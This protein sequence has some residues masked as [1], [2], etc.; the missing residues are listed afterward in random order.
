MLKPHIVFDIE[1]VL[2]EDAVAR[3]H[4]LA[5]GDVN[6]VKAVIGDT[7]PKP[8]FHKIVAI[9][10]TTLTYDNYS[11]QWSVLEMASLHTG[12]QTEKDLVGK[13]V[14]YV[15]R[16]T[17]TLV[18][19]N[20]L[21]F[22]L[23]V[24][25]ARAMLYRQGSWHMAQ[26]NFRPFSEHHVDLCDLLAVRSRTRMTLD[27]VVRTFGIGGAGRLRRVRRRHDAAYRH[28]QVGRCLQVLYVFDL[29]AAGQDSLQR[30]LNP[31]GQARRSRYEPAG[32]APV[33][34]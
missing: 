32:R 14:D 28:V 11:R 2:D 3:A 10:A 4:K 19:Y 30:P 20:S 9:A 6:A 33:A 25:R 12:D 16:M 29:R 24:V 27:E 18:G 31:D 15:R 13:F 8:A 26:F 23:P 1:T 5:P 17:P 21:A 22:D 34:A 7:F